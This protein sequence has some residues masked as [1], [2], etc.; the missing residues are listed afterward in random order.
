M[1]LSQPMLYLMLSLFAKEII[2]LKEGYFVS[3]DTC[4]NLAKEIENKVFEIA[5]SQEDL[6]HF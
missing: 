4:E 2:L 6:L 5:I 1:V 3:H